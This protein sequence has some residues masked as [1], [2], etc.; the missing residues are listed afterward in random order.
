MTRYLT[1]PSFRHDLFVCISCE[2]VFKSV[3]LVTKT[4]AD[5]KLAHADT[6]L[7]LQSVRLILITF[8]CAKLLEKCD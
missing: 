1:A 3:R 6:V 5:V 7:I 2:F 4:F 8:V